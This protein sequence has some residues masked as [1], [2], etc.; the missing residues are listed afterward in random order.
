MEVSNIQIRVPRKLRKDT[1]KVLS[2]IGVDLSTAIRMFMNQ[3]VYSR[4]IP[5]ELKIPEESDEVRWEYVPVDDATQS[6]MDKLGEAMDK[7][8]KKRSR[9]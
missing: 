5:F 3:V 2:G 6:K 7:A 8:L 9:K 1:D 4:G